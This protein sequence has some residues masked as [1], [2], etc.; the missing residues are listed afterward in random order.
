MINYKDK[1]FCPFW[2]TCKAGPGCD[3]ALTPTVR[4]E[5]HRW[6]GGA[7]AP[8]C[9]LKDKPECWEAQ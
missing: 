2:D 9:L 6:W 1:T 8:I 7:G 5:A 3:R 4:E